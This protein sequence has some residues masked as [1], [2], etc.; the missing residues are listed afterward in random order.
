MRASIF[1]RISTVIL[2]SFALSLLV[3]LFWAI[4]TLADSRL[5][6][7][8][9]QLLKAEIAIDFNRTISRY[10]RSGDATLLVDAEKQ[11]SQISIQA[12][13]IED[14]QLSA[15]IKKQANN[16][17][18][19]LSTDFR[20][21][22]KQSGDPMALLK[23][24]ELA[25]T[26][27]VEQLARFVRESNAINT[28]TQLRYIQLTGGIATTLNS[29][30]IQ[31]QA[32]FNAE[33]INSNALSPLL[34]SLKQQNKMLSE[35][36]A[37]EIYVTDEDEDELGFDDEEAEDVSEEALSELNSAINRYQSD[38]DL[39][40]QQQTNINQ[41]FAMLTQ[42]V[43][44]L[45]Q[46]VIAGQK[47]VDQDSEVINDNVKTIVTAVVVLLLIVVAVSY[48]F[49]LLWILKP[50]RLLRN[51]FKE[52][53]ETGEVKNI[54]GMDEQTELGEISVSFNQMV[55]KLREEDKQKAQQLSLVSAALNS[56]QQQADDIYQTSTTSASHV[57][58][59]RDIMT[60][61]GQATDTVNELSTQVVDTAK[62]TQ[63][64]MTQS[65]VQVEQALHA[66]ES[67]ATA[68]ESGKASIQT[69]GQS[70]DS[71]STIVEVIS[72]I[73]DQTNLLALNAAIEAARAGEHGRGF[74][75]VA[76]EVR[77]LASKTQDSL[78]QISKRLEQLQLA[79][80]TLE[81][82]IVDI[83]V[84]SSQ[85]K[86]IASQLKD[87]ADMVVEQAQTSASVAQ[88]TLSHITQQRSHYREFSAAMADVA[89]KVKQS[90]T[91]ANNISNDV[92]QQ[93]TDISKTLAVH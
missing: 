56:M 23:N 3:T 70:V 37:L 29:L 44:L 36:P 21:L 20:A 39:T 11:L 53:V 90:Q 80:K 91:I 13:S 43:E 31:R 47:V 82:F 58:T 15:S 50:L 54:S 66:S 88:D 4:T 18:Q 87:N 40:V 42:Q 85:Q 55:E 81:Q 10:F 19:L 7:K 71:V 79:S 5:Q 34:A 2:I 63:K 68:A 6:L 72:S 60:L 64:A 49:Q 26:G 76:D 35:L 16:L 52:L 17:V 45:E 12:D 69:L 86:H 22:G 57:D 83:A 67:T 9:Y 92:N 30:I 59:L 89:D 74:S 77:Q 84:A 25:I 75:V 46:L 51:S 48:L 14:Q 27:S 1:F 61:L 41:G 28:A 62:A 73:A 78:G 65:Q 93:V 38:L 8:Q 32:M 24:S 33:V